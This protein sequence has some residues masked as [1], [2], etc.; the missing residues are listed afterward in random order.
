MQTDERPPMAFNATDFDISNYP[1]VHLSPLETE[2]Y[3]VI[4]DIDTFDDM[5]KENFKLFRNLA[6]NRIKEFHEKKI[7][8]S[9][10]YELWKS[11][12]LVEGKR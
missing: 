12:K 11:H 8:F 9:D 1:L 5:A 6:M 3:K 10:G 7:V 4:D 2:L